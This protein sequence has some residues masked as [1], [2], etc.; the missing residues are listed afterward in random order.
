MG[1]CDNHE[2]GVEA[3]FGCHGE[4]CKCA[5]EKPVPMEARWF[6]SWAPDVPVEYGDGKPSTPEGFSWVLVPAKPEGTS[7]GEK[8]HYSGRDLEPIQVM[9][10]WSLDFLEGNALKY[11]AR[12]R[13]KNGI[14][15]L[16]KVKWYV[17]RII[18]R[19][20]REGRA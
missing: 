17:D 10:A 20:R 11:L 5:E 12:Y 7:P 4:R 8:G 19:E 6:R 9:E 14:E 2:C 1:E 13:K 15:D 16:E 18:Q 3:C